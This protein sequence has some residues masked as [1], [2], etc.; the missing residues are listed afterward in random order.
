MLHLHLDPLGGIAGDM[1]AAALLDAFPEQRA[2]VESAASS[3][4]GVACALEP[5]RG[6]VLAGSRFTVMRPAGHAHAHPG[7]GHRAWRDIRAHLAGAG[8]PEPARRHAEGIFAVLAE[9][10]AQVHG[11][12]AED[13]TFHEV[14]AAD[15]IADIVAA[16]TLIAALGEARWSV[17]P[18]PLGSGRVSTAHGP[19]PVPAPATALL[20]RGFP[21]LDDGIAGERVTPTGAAILRYLGA[22]SAVPPG[23]RRLARSG[24]GFG[25]RRLA[26]LS[27]CLRLLV[28]EPAEEPGGDRRRL[29]VI[30]FEVD[31]QSPEDLAAGLERLR[32]APGVLDV[33]QMPAFAKKGRLAAHVQVL[34]REDAAEAAVSA[35]FRETTTIGLRL[36]QVEGRTLKRRM[37]R[38]TVGD[39]DVRV[40]LVE[41]PGGTTAKAESEDARGA[42]G[43]SARAALRREAELLALRAEVPP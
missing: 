40:K 20:L 37:S 16:G 38:V 21:V 11:I 32:T 29:C 31:D 41:R 3:V 13:V 26:G 28:F 42:D 18:L 1:F 22:G 27:N 43:Q 6:D 12:A 33:V 35:C 36:Q 2:A 23:V 10:E 39:T 34:A 30:G 19:L 7:H 25:T 24:T 14:G 15:S 4:A 17:G 5:H 9:A 8:L